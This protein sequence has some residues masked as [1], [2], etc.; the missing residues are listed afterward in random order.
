MA[1]RADKPAP[2]DQDTLARSLTV[3]RW[4]TG[5]ILDKHTHAWTRTRYNLP[6]R[7]CVRCRTTEHS[8]PPP[9]THVP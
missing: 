9:M 2:T 1:R 6:T 4:A 8:P 5:G 7:R 3:E